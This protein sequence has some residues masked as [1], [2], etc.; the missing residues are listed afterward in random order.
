MT[1]TKVKR[2]KRRKTDPK[3]CELSIEKRN[4]PLFS[5]DPNLYPKQ[6]DFQMI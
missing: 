1:I 4:K 6:N 5:L 2:H 3:L